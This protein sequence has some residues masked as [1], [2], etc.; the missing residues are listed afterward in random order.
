MSTCTSIGASLWIYILASIGT[1]IGVSIEASIGAYIGLL[2]GLLLR[3]VWGFCVIF[4][5]GF[6]RPSF[7]F[8]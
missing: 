3:F 7:G 5:V 1:Y 2:Y 4:Y 8:L 6:I